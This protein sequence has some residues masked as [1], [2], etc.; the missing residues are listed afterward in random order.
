M[1]K[2]QNITLFCV[3]YSFQQ[4]DLKSEFKKAIEESSN[5]K[6]PE[7]NSVLCFLFLSINRFEE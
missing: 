7:Y 4:I 5:G 3:S 6:I 1:V 2:F